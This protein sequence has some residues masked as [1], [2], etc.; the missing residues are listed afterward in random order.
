MADLYL[1]CYPLLALVAYI[2]HRFV[3]VDARLRAIP[4]IG[5]STLFISWFFLNRLITHVRVYL[6]E[7]YRK[8]RGS[9][10]KIAILDRWFVFVTGPT[11]IEDMRRAPDDQLSARI[12]TEDSI[13]IQYT[14]GKE[15]TTSQFHIDVV[16]GRLTKQFGVKFLETRDEVLAAFDD[17]LPLT[18][19]WVKVQDLTGTLQRIISRS[20]N[21]LFVGL[22]LCRDPQYRDLNIA[23]T[24]QLKQDFE[25][26]SMCPEFLKPI[27]GPLFVRSRQ[28]VLR[29]VELLRQLLQRRL[30][31]Y[32]NRNESPKDLIAW[33]IDEAPPEKKTVH[34]LA[35]RVLFVNNAAIHTTSMAFTHALYFLATYPYY[36][37]PLREE[38]EA[39]VKEH[40]WT[41]SA[42]GKMVKLDSFLKES[43]RLTGLGAAG[44]A[45]AVL[46]NFTFSDG[47]TVPAGNILAV[48]SQDI[49]LDE[50]IY[51]KA[52]DFQGFRYSDKRTMEGEGH[53]HHFVTIASDYM[54][55]GYGRH[56]CPGRFFAAQ[57]MAIMFAHILTAYDV[58]FWGDRKTQPEPLSF[59]F[60]VSPDPKVELVFRARV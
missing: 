9:A 59:G 17:E 12:N 18:K 22:P 3:R 56:A 25:R 20:S 58:K 42:I 19:D 41:K 14:L 57:S 15:L 53:K 11:M 28:T 31:D 50:A 29:G 24:E 55:F 5:P 51:P 13:S 44:M 23:L 10:F 37:T 34:E 2:F 7:G 40:G 32:H 47:T 21:R 52:H 30:E 26:L 48:A 8:H 60:T 39:V 4:T 43:Q 35:I 49:H 16:R 33:L 27:V 38:I 54:V 46:K 1:L 6:E 36:V 45:R